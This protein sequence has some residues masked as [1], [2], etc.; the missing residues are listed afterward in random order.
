M[1]FVEA[2]SVNFKKYGQFSG[3]ARRAE[4]WFWVLFYALVTIVAGV[5]DVAIAG[6]SGIGVIG[7]IAS[8]VLALPSLAVTVRRFHDIDKSGWWMLV[9]FIPLVGLIFFLVWMIPKGTTG[10]N[11]FGEDPLG[12]EAADTAPMLA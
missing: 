9:M 11:R 7:L 6:I 10:A 12:G 4:Y 3:R 1:N 8:L 5:L 2:I